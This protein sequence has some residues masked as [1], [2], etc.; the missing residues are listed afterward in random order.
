MRRQSFSASSERTSSW[1]D[2]YVQQADNSCEDE[3]G[4]RRRSFS[5]CSEEERKQRDEALSG[6]GWKCL[7]W[8]FRKVVG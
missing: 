8:K 4:E 1:D 5:V 6:V 7:S 2:Y 3:L